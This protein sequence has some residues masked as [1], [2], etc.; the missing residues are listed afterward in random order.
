MI[1]VG[2]PCGLS[3][4]GVVL[5]CAVRSCAPAFW[6]AA[7]LWAGFIN[8]PELVE[9]A[10]SESAESEDWLACGAASLE[11]FCEGIIKPCEH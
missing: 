10:I 11:C 5:F 4:C 6:L 2:E 7:I 9:C 8:C 3:V 1:W